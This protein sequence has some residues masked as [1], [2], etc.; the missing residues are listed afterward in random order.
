MD[1][2][3]DTLLTEVAKLWITIRGFSYAGNLIER[4]KQI[5]K[6]KFGKK[7]LRKSLWLENEK[8]T[9]TCNSN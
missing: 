1:D 4:Y 7:S 6:S 8:I 5:S 9:S 2:E 3:S